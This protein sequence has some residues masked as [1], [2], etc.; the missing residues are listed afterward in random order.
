MEHLLTNQ[1][2]AAKA[3]GRVLGRVSGDVRAALVENIAAALDGAKISIL[4]ANS[5]DVNAAE[6][7]GMS[8]TLIDR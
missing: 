2:C 1:L 5:I 7:A 3:A 8:V 4:A 6:A